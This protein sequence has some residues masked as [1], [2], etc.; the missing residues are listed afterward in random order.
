[1]DAV[2]GS[3][4]SFSLDCG[5]GLAFITRARLYSDEE[6]AQLPPVERCGFA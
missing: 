1:V 5:S 4:G 6:L 2:P 3:S